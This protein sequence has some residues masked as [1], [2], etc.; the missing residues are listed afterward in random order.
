[1]IVFNKSVQL[2]INNLESLL[3]TLA[4]ENR[5]HVPRLVLLYPAFR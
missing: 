5:I 3:F 1:M 2:L 4:H